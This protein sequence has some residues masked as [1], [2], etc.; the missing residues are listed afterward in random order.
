[1]DEADETNQSHAIDQ[2]GLLVDW[3]INTFAI[4]K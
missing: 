4:S 1:M 3:T 2:K